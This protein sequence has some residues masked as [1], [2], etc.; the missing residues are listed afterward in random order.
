MPTTRFKVRC[1]SQMLLITLIASFSN[2]ECCIT[3]NWDV[4]PLPPSAHEQVA[5]SA[6]AVTSPHNYLALVC[7]SGLSSLL[8]STSLAFVHIAER[9]GGGN[10]YSHSRAVVC[11]TDISIGFVTTEDAFFAWATNNTDGQPVAGIEIT[12]YGY[13]PYQ[14][15][16]R[17]GALCHLCVCSSRS[18]TSVLQQSIPLSFEA[19]VYNMI[20][21]AQMCSRKKL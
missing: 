12:V 6:R 16:A 3:G 8:E 14:V 20:S 15:G 5:T 19:G 9:R 2:N 13:L 11:S 4:L 7:R 21:C 18:F 10:E 1:C 17:F